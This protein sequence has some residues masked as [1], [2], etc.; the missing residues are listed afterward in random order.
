[1]SGLGFGKLGKGEFAITGDVPCFE[2]LLGFANGRL[3]CGLAQPTIINV[4]SKS[5][6]IFILGLRC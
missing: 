1:M 5:S 3:L 4:Q 2:T 6:S